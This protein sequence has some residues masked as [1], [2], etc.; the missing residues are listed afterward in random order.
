MYDGK[1]YQLNLQLFAKVKSDCQF[2]VGQSVR[3]TFLKMDEDNEWPR[4]IS[5]KQKYRNIQFDVTSTIKPDKKRLL[6]Q[7]DSDAE[8][9]KKRN[10]AKEEDSSDGEFIYE[11]HSDVD[12][13]I[14]DIEDN[15]E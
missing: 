9:E 14:S 4:L 8:L 2:T 11:F 3:V 10:E 15:L 13:D 6:F 1:D 12:Y 5:G 7:I